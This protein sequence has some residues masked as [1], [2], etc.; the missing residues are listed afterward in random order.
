MDGRADNEKSPDILYPPKLMRRRS[1]G[2]PAVAFALR[3]GRQGSPKG[4]FFAGEKGKDGK[5]LK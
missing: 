4:Y 1:H 2:L 3:A 5:K